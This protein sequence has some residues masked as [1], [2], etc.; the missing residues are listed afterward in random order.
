M[1]ELN[2]KEIVSKIVKELSEYFKVS[3]FMVL[4]GIAKG[5]ITMRN[6]LNKRLS[7]SL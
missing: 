5:N 6:M 7:E 2:K 1:K 4:N 3:E